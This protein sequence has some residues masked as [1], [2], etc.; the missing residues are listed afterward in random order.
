MKDASTDPFITQ[1]NIVKRKSVH[2]QFI[3]R[4]TPSS[5]QNMALQTRRSYGDLNPRSPKFNFIRLNRNKSEN[6]LCA[7][8]V[9]VFF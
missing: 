2:N 9:S 8:K 4:K 5:I 7:K 3:P 1:I 6:K